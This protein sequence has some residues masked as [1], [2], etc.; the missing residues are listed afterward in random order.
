MSNKPRPY[1]NTYIFQVWCLEDSLDHIEYIINFL[2]CPQVT[3]RSLDDGNATQEDTLRCVLSW[4][5]VGV[6]LCLP[7]DI[8]GYTDLMY[9][10]MYSNS[11]VFFTGSF[12]KFE[13]FSFSLSYLY[14]VFHNSI[15]HNYGN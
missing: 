1:K 3:R 15:W 4:L 9:L 12:T 8:A 10:F 13:D 14:R 5:A 6:I 11:E 2:H 7:N